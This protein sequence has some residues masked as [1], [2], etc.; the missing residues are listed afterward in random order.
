MLWWCMFEG[1]LRLLSQQAV[2]CTHAVVQLR[3]ERTDDIV[4]L[5]RAGQH[6]SARKL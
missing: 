6:A 5:A 1:V 4:L 3:L 2:V